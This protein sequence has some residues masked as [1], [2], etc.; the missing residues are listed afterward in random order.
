MT[1]Q[2]LDIQS[3]YINIHQFIK[4]EEVVFGAFFFSVVLY[5]SSLIV[6]PA[7]QPLKKKKVYPLVSM[8]INLCQEV[9]AEPTC[10]CRE[11]HDK[12]SVPFDH[13][14]DDMFPKPFRPL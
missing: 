6:I 1:I 4:I 10:S 14:C 7:S 12:V 9:S 3:H 5:D 11:E 2:L 8:G 13:H